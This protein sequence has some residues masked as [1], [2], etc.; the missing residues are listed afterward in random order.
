MAAGSSTHVKV[1]ALR[2]PH[3]LK[4]MVKAKIFLDDPGLLVTG[5]PLLLADGSTLEVAD[6]QAVGQ[7]L[8]ALSIKGVNSVE[9]AGALRGDVFLDR[10]NWPEVA[11]EVYLDTLV[12]QDVLGPDGAVA[13]R[14]AA[15]ATLPAGPALEIDAGGKSTAIVPVEDAFVSLGDTV[16]LTEVGMALLDL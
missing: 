2:G 15:I 9:A 6:W 7:G 3:G 12:G 1:G 13:G 10:S 16:V 14:I 8:L 4:G 11:G 5:G